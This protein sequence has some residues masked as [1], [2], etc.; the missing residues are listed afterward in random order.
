M[1]NVLAHS[2]ERQKL[3]KKTR[4][5]PLTGSLHLDEM[6]PST[7]KVIADDISHIKDPETGLCSGSM[8]LFASPQLLTGERGKSILDAILNKD[9]SSALHMVVMDEVHIAS[10]FGNTFRREFRLLKPRLYT[11]LPNCCK[12]RLFMT[13]TCTKTIL[14]QVEE[15]A[16]FRI[17]NRHWPTKEEMRHRSVSIRLI[18]TPLILNV[19]KRSLGILLK[20]GSADKPKKAIIY[21]NMRIKIIGIGKK[22]GGFLNTDGH[23]YKID[24]MVIHG[25]LSQEEKAGY[26][27][28]FMETS[29]KRDMRVLLATSGVANAGID[30]SKIH[31]AIRIEFPPSIQD[32]CQEKGRVGRV[33]NAS[34]LIYSYQICFDIDSFIL[35]VKRTLNP[36][37]KMD[38]TFRDQMMKDHLDVVKLFCTIDGCFNDSFERA[39]SNPFITNVESVDDST[40]RCNN[41]PG[42][43][44]TI[45][46]MFNKISIC[47][48]KNILFVA[49]T[50]QTSYNINDLVDC[51]LNQQNI[52]RRLF[53]RRRRDDNMCHCCAPFGI[54]RPFCLA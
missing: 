16:G 42:C 24:Y 38:Q 17:L 34:P 53:H 45:R 2:L 40:N 7:I 11:K 27:K 26:L 31:T 29:P 10:Q 39:L 41:C 8:I 18:Y 21:S 35:L 33:P 51:I 20:Q 30:S 15:L 22:L 52:D 43:D 13:G 36:D 54:K 47:G 37:E 3:K 44:G 49:F 32:I 23:L 6:K 4:D 9:S 28:L 48:A 1:L 25:Q 12:I 19:I 14:T 50:K 5:I 46:D